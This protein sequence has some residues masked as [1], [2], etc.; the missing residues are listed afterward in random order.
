MQG[1]FASAS[2]NE[3]PPSAGIAGSAEGR[4]PVLYDLYS[5]TG[6]I[7][8]VLAPVAGNVYGIEL[9]PEAVEAAKENAALN[10]IE[11]CT[12][13]AGD[14][15]EKL[16]EIEERPDYIILDPP[17]EG[18][19][20]KSLSK[21]ISYGVNEMVYISCKASSFK[22]DMA[23]LRD[24]GFRVKRWCLVDMFPE[25]QHVETVVLLTHS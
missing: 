16:G 21:I 7:A 4:R 9:I 23:V 11:N 18:I 22:S 20:P 12:F 5:G 15:F 10:G 13:L 24:F 25:T 1:L 8:Q 3:T 2:E 19:L 6:T 14:V 17:R